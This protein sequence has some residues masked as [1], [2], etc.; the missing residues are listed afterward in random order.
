MTE[1]VLEKSEDAVVHLF[2]DLGNEPLTQ[3][4]VDCC[5]R[6]LGLGEQKR[7]IEHAEFGDAIGQVAARLIAEREQPVFHQP[8]DVLGPIAEVHDVPNILDV[9][10]VAELGRESVADTLEG[11][12]E[13][14]AWRPV[15]PHTNLD[16]IAHL[17]LRTVIF[18]SVF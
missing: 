5:A 16:L 18:R 8:Q 6:L 9:D 2:L 1:S 12:T 17:S 14:G 11:E 15:A 7:E 10:A 3:S 4:A 13:T